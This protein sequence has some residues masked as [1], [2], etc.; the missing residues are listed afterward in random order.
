MKNSYCRQTL[1]ILLSITFTAQISALEIS[2]NDSRLFVGTTNDKF[3]YG[4]SQNRDDQLTAT[5]E[6]HIILPYVFVD[7]E[8]NSITNRG[9]KS[10]MNNPAT[11]SSGRYDE[12]IFKTGTKVNFLDKNIF[13]IDFIP[14]IG[15]AFLGNFGMEFEQNANHKS[16]GVDLVYL[17]FEKFENPFLPIINSAIDFSFTPTDFFKAK[18]AFASN[19][20]IFYSTEQKF[21]F[22]VEFGKKSLLSLFT[23][24]TWNQT[25]NDSVALKTYKDVT[26]GFNFGFS[27]DT[28]FAKF[29]YINYLNTNY[30]L[31]RISVD[32]LSLA[33]HNWEK[34]DISFSTGVSF[35]IGT[36][37]LENQI[38]TTPVNNISF[39]FN[40][41]YVFGFKTNKVNPSDYRFERDYVI[42]TLG[43]KYEYPLEFTENWISPYIKIGAGVASFGIER[44]ANQIPEA[45][46]YSYK[47][48]TKNFWQIEAN[49]GVD[50]IPEGKLNF[51]NS[52]YRLT[53]FAGTIITPNYLAAT[54]Q[55]KLDTYRPENWSLNLFEVVYG[56]AVHIGLDF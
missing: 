53:V 56:L 52:T 42:N 41:K 37:F 44:H 22:N 21:V 5:N 20:M 45:N 25:Q 35:F 29:D 7:V 34:T 55:I 50:I 19:N 28:G 12:L 26:N 38:E 27:L 39:Y 49:I 14:E 48:E 54:E 18:I 3:A 36:E 2:K 6:I 33:K 51:G 10:D 15:V 47:Y 30:G 8:L 31:G 32:L 4:I 24:Y 9:Y 40:N 17:E 16:S 46:Y 11:F 13:E 43:V 1:I 23:G